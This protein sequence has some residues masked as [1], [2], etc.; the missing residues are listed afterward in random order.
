MAH[1]E[2]LATRIPPGAKVRLRDHDPADT[3][4]MKRDK[5]ETQTQAHWAEFAE[6]QELL[7]GAARQSVLIILQGMDTSGKDG[8]IQ[9]VMTPIN[10]Q[11]C[12]VV[13][14][15]QPTPADL[16]HDFLWRVH[17]FTPAKGMIGI[18][19][20]SHYEDV[21][22]V[23]VHN[24]APKAVWE[25]RYDAINQFER[26]LAEDGTII[27]KFFLHISKDEQRAR[28]L[29]REKDPTKAWKL[30]PG[31]W[32]EREK[33]DDY[34]AAYEAAL[35]KCSTKDAPWYIVPADK[36][37][38]RNLIITDTILKTLRPHVTSWQAALADRGKEQLAAIA[39]LQARKTT[40][41]P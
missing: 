21:L 27:L 28:L 23:R 38:F 41:H 32:I 34:Q 25:R 33:W 10:P 16:A 1:D 31:D 24:L 4:E 9:H 40:D 15:K 30:S 8:T 20:R 11:G 14:F 6:T 2:L 3:K 22:V 37:W 35:S 19:N 5:A 18:F 12:S 39:Q 29:A 36:K 17:P 26:V 13:A 7:Y